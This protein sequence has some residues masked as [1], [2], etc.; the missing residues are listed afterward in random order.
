M[1]AWPN[2][3]PGKLRATSCKVLRTERV[4]SMRQRSIV[5]P[6]NAKVWVSSWVICSACASALRVCAEVRGGNSSRTS[7]KTRLVAPAG[8]M[9]MWRPCVTRRGERGWFGG[10]G[11]VA[12]TAVGGNIASASSQPTG[13]SIQPNVV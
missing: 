5:R 12:P 2:D 13:P 10:V 11:G 4:P 9:L 1:F 8:G 7:F 6:V 3:T